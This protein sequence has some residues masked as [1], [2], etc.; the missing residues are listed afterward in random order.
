MILGM[1]LD[2]RDVK[3]SSEDFILMDTSEWTAEDL[4]KAEAIRQEGQFFVGQ[5]SRIDEKEYPDAAAG[6]GA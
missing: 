1:A 3:G 2:A 4:A 5:Q 6:P